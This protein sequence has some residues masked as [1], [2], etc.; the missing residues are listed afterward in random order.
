MIGE[1]TLKS[2][3]LWLILAF[4]CITIPLNAIIKTNIQTDF[5]ARND[6]GANSV[7][8]GEYKLFYRAQAQEDMM[9][10]TE[11]VY[12]QNPIGGFN[13][14]VV[15]ERFDIER[16]FIIYNLSSKFQFKIGRFHTNI[17]QWNKA[18]ERGSYFEP[19]ITRPLVADNLIIPIDYAGVDLRVDG[20]IIGL[21]NTVVNMGVGSSHRLQ[22]MVVL[23]AF[24]NLNFNALKEEGVTATQ[25]PNIL[26][27]YQVIPNPTNVSP[28]FKV[29]QKNLGIEGLNVGAGI[30]QNFI[31]NRF[32]QYIVSS[33]L[34]FMPYYS[35]YE[36][37]AEAMY[38]KHELPN[39]VE[40]DAF[41]GGFLQVGRH[42]YYPFLNEHQKVYARFEATT[43]YFILGKRRVYTAGIS[44]EINDV[45]TSKLE[46]NYLD[47][48]DASGDKLVVTFQNA[49]Y[50]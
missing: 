17:S 11:M 22:S 2:K 25:N 48:V 47:I 37:L 10:L 45:A 26:N 3:A 32:S 44:V 46:L 43:P 4:F 8:V 12:R 21:D 34:E 6:D 41:K 36:V 27:G 19:S 15:D 28:H 33:F 50:Y 35:D 14:A 39:S 24:Y 49:I 7:S 30:Y 42:F 9:L 13:Q 38:I 16:L 18:Y 5:N 40:Q 23:N 31:N 29:T 20:S 1:K